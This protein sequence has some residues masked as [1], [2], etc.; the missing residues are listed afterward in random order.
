MPSQPWRPR[1]DAVRGYSSATGDTSE[2]YQRTACEQLHHS[3]G[4]KVCHR[5]ADAENSRGLRCS[6]S[7]QIFL[8]YQRVVTHPT[9]WKKRKRPSDRVLPPLLRS[10]ERSHMNTTDLWELAQSDPLL[11]RLGMGKRLKPEDLHF[12][13]V[14]STTV[15]LQ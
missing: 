1:L 6:N 2:A 3:Y 12:S 5:V 7:C 15:R 11:Q 14:S 13:V 10:Q 8:Q 4:R 9:S